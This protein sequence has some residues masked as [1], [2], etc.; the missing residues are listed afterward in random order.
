L[1]SAACFASRPAA[2]QG[3]RRK[4]RL[5]RLVTP[6][7]WWISSLREERVMGDIMFIVNARRRARAARGCR[8]RKIKSSWL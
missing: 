5:Q 1:L 3:E 6:E 2:K 7:D 4:R 8:M